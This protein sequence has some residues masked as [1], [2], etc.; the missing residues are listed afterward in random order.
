MYEMIK[1]VLG[2]SSKSTLT[3]GTFIHAKKMLQFRQRILLTHDGNVF[4]SIIFSSSC[5]TTISEAVAI[6]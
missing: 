4:L 3:T 6:Q 5:V 2:V 1:C